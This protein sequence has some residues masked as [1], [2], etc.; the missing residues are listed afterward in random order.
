RLDQFTRDALKAGEDEGRVVAGRPP[1]AHDD[2]RPRRVRRAV[3]PVGVRADP[4]HPEDVV[5]GPELA[6]E[7]QVEHE[8]YHDERDRDG[9]EVR[10]PERRGDALEA[11]VQDERYDGRQRQHDGVVDEDVEERVRHR[12]P[13]GPVA[14]QLAVVRQADELG[15]REAAPAREAER[16]RGDYRDYP[17]SCER[18][19]E[20]Q[21]EQVRRGW[22]GAGG[23][24][25]RHD[26]QARGWGSSEMTPSRGLGSLTEAYRPSR[27]S[28]SCS[29]RSMASW[30]VT[31][32]SKSA[33]ICSPKITVVSASEKQF[34]LGESRICSVM[35][36]PPKKGSGVLSRSLARAGW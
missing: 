3:K 5:D 18:H 17:E 34:Q 36:S 16:E 35:T 10:R 13:E 7:E 32:P 25:G 14:Q 33:S 12:P 4:Q 11:G 24:H 23:A 6:I 28:T 22:R 1:H 15:L 31:R 29:K 21:Q 19:E 30:T 27:C 2:D 20:R 9:D 8:G 26:P